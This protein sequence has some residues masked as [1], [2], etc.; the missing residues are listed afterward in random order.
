MR[1]LYRIFWNAGAISL[2]TAVWVFAREKQT[3]ESLVGKYGESFYLLPIFFFGYAV[4]TG[5][6]FRALSDI[7]GSVPRGNP[8]PVRCF[9][10]CI[11]L[12]GMMGE[13]VFCSLQDGPIFGFLAGGSF[14]LFWFVIA[15]VPFS[16]LVTIHLGKYLW[17]H[18]RSP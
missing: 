7:A 9:F 10:V 1:H 17:K 16:V 18:R 15:S 11:C 13:S 5:M 12:L 4:L 6:V 3:A 14:A 2:A 8:P